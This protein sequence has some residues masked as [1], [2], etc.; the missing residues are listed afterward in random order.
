MLVAATGLAVIQHERN[1][2][3]I[4]AGIERIEHA[5]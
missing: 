1:R 5:A 3:R 4:E 2:F